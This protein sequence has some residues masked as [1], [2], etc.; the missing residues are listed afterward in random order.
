M[1]NRAIV[2]PE[3]KDIGVYLHW[4]GGIDSVTAFLKYCELKEHRGFDDSY[5]MARFCQVVGNFFGGSLSIGIETGVNEDEVED[6]WLDNGIYVVKDWD[7]VRHVGGGNSREGYDLDEFLKEIDARQPLKEQLGEF[8]DAVETTVN[9]IKVG[10]IVFIMNVS[11]R[12]EKHEVIGIGE[13]RFVN[14]R[15]VL[16]IPYVQRYGNG[17]DNINNYI[18]ERARVVRKEKECQNQ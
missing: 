11:G 12:Y 15:N 7:I 17:P 10:D 16:G 4:N 2:K 8:L 9:E 5:G 3:G 1:G 18:F 14:G 13:H 6:Y